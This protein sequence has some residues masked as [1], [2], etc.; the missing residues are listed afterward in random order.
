M[1]G[2]AG[3]RLEPAAPSVTA[4][5]MPAPTTREGGQTLKSCCRRRP[6]PR[7]GKL[8]ISQVAAEPYEEIKTARSSGSE[9]GGYRHVTDGGILS[10]PVVGNRALPSCRRP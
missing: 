1:S 8:T 3:A 4:A 5:Q 9:R 6:T 10:C 7:E 2:A